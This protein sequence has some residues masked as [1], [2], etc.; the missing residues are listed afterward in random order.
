[1][2]SIVKQC[3]NNR[4]RVTCTGADCLPIDKLQAFQAGIK[5]LPQRNADMLRSRILKHGINVP[6][7]IWKYQDSFYILDGHQRIKVLSA[8]QTEGYE[9]PMLPVDYI[10]ADSI[11]DAKDKLL[12]ITS[13]YGVFNLE[14]LDIFLEDVEIEDDVRLTDDEINLN[15][16]NPTNN[17]PQY[18]DGGINYQ[19][20][21]GVIVI[22]EDESHQQAVYEKLSGAGYS[23]RVVKT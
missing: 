3:E 18:N 4:I 17:Q 7:F 15:P 5:D 14:E 12:G 22:C 2:D 20:Q 19:E 1:M 11:I 21:Y 10:E 13:Q 6:L 9:I 23:C 8:L 16:G